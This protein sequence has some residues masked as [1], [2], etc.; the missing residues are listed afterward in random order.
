M[1]ILDFL[2]GNEAKRC[3]PDDVLPLD[4]PSHTVSCNVRYCDFPALPEARGSLA[5]PRR[6][7]VSITPNCV[8]NPARPAAVMASARVSLCRSIQPS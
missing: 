3:V 6:Y 8:A 5:R 1:Q 4:S 7:P 2:A